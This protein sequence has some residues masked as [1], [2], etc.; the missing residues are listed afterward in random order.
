MDLSGIDLL[1]EIRGILSTV[2]SGFFELCVM[3][4]IVSPENSYAKALTPT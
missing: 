2:S 4:L 3:D 1:K